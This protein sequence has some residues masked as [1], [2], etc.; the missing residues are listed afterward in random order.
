LGLTFSSKDASSGISFPLAFSANSFIQNRV[1][2]FRRTSYPTF[3]SKL[4]T[5][6]EISIIINS[7]LKG[8]LLR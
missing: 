3:D 4:S 6:A 1:Y 2:T 5:N 7:L 8:V